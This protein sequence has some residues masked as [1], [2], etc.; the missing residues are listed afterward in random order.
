MSNPQL[1]DRRKFIRSTA[2]AAGGEG[3]N[4]TLSKPLMAAW[5][6]VDVPQCGYCQTGQIMSAAV[7]LR[8]NSNPTDEDIDNAMS[9]NICRCATYQRIRKAIHL[10]AQLK[11]SGWS[12]CST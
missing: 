7:L 9:G 1:I 11:R 5:A 10:A 8:D 6:E 12:F 4:A 3:L 2:L